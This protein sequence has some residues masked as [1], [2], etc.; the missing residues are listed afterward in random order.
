M[1]HSFSVSNKCLYFPQCYSH[2]KMMLYTH[3]SKTEHITCFESRWW[4]CFLEEKP[5][6]LLLFRIVAWKSLEAPI[7]VPVKINT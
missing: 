3:H 1:L 4:L 7:N 6:L 2:V 5:E